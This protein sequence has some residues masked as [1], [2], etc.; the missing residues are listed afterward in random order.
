MNTLSF[1][2]TLP[3]TL[4]ALLSG[5]PVLYSA[6]P[7]IGKNGFIEGTLFPYL[8]QH[9]GVV[10]YMY[11]GLPGWEGIDLM[12]V[13]NLKDKE[14]TNLTNFEQ[15]FSCTEPTLV[16]LD[17]LGQSDITLQKV[18]QRIL[19]ERHLNGRKIPDHVYFVAATNDIGQGADVEMLT[20]LI[21]RMMIFNVETNY[22][23]WF[24]NF[25]AEN[26]SRMHPAIFAAVSQTSGPLFNDLEQVPEG[27]EPFASI[28]SAT[29]AAISARKS[30]KAL[31]RQLTKNE[32]Y[33]LV[34]GSCGESYAN[35]VVMHFQ[36]QNAPTLEDVAYGRYKYKPE[37]HS[38]MYYHMALC[39]QQDLKNVQQMFYVARFIQEL[40]TS[41]DISSS[42]LRSVL[43]DRMLSR[44]GMITL[45]KK[46]RD[47]K[48]QLPPIDL[49]EYFKMYT[50]L[51]SQLA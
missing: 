41:E 8:Q 27:V 5:T 44:K 25:G 13:P 48:G 30:E 24:R 17:E 18:L 29:N 19:N 14:Y 39:L 23:E 11:I 49:S 4:G 40:S 6:R 2:Q 16:F 46:H 20:P 7:G 9:L 35:A 31:G 33:H 43:I 22:D 34:K 15:V 38:L 26:A 50:E 12:G 28:R 3:L 42:E 32:L 47:P 1:N 36:Y 45:V 10:H 21:N 51:Q 37:D